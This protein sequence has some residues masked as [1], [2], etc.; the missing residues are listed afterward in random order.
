M[1]AQE[2]LN[3][4]IYHND[5]EALNN[6]NEQYA[7]D[8]E[9]MGRTLTWAIG[10][11]SKYNILEVLIDMGADLNSR[12]RLFP[13]LI[14]A[15]F[16]VKTNEA[17]VQIIQDLIDLG[18]DVNIRGQL[19]QTPLMYAAEMNMLNVARVLIENG[20]NVELQNAN[21]RTAMDLATTENMRA[22]LNS[23]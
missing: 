3:D 6:V 18:A 17:T 23:V 7:F 16:S 9:D 2:E 13:A 11:G 10:M 4:A 14:W 22:L 5:I 21:G 19:S 15:V 8:R 12:N 20:A 1:D